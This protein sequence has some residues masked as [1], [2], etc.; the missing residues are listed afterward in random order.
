M[1]D[2]TALRRAADAGGS[3]ETVAVLYEL[4]NTAQSRPS[5]RE[6]WKGS[7]LMRARLP[8]IVK[9]FLVEY[10]RTWQRLNRVRTQTPGGAAVKAWLLG[11]FENQRQRFLKLRGDLAKD[12]Y[13]WGDVLNWIGENH[14]AIARLNERLESI[15]RTLP[16]D[17]QRAVDRAFART[18]GR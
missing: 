15:L 4:L 8:Q 14:T 9:R 18:P 11:S 1:D 17:Q 5:D 16:I 3:D 13:A 7:A 12:T 10:S 2:I 6:G